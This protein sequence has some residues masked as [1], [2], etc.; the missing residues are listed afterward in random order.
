MT[1]RKY[2]DSVSYAGIA[3]AGLRVRVEEREGETQTHARS[4]RRLDSE[5]KSE[6][7]IREERERE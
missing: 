5:R 6:R 4:E 1:E 2:V 3:R 7:E